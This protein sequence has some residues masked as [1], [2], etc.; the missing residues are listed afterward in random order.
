MKKE[1]I[2]LVMSIFLIGFVFAQGQ[3]IHD[4]GTGI[5]NPELKEAWQG[6]GQGI[7]AKSGDFMGEN[8]KRINLQKQTNN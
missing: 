3:G 2:I 4:A 5:E 7:M 1:M 8:G 6:T